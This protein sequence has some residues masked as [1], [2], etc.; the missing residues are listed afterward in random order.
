[1]SVKKIVTTKYVGQDEHA[2]FEFRFRPVEDSITIEKNTD[3][4]S[5]AVYVARY[6]VRDKER[7][8]KKSAEKAARGLIE[9]WN[10]YLSGDVYG[11]VREDYDK[12]KTR[13]G[14]EECW[15][16]YGYDYALKALKTDI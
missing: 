7:R 1:M 8:M 14:G 6:L 9:T 11:I 2:G 10:A 4:K 3:P 15:G 13:I 5:T 16:F 12:N